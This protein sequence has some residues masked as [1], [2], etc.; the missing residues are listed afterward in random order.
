[1]I[2]SNSYVIKL[3]INFDVSSIFYMKDLV[4]IKHNN[5][6]SMILL[7]P[8]PQLDDQIQTILGLSKRHHS[9]LIMIFGSVIEAALNYTR[10][11]QVSPTLEEL[12]VILDPRHY[13]RTRI[14]IEDGG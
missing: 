8:L 3:S 1:M 4:Y 7:K 13:L 5:L 6:S 2:E 11:G 14:I 10:Q 9:S 12:M